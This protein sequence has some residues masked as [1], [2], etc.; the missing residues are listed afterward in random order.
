MAIRIPTNAKAERYESLMRCLKHASV[1]MGVNEFFAARFMT[2]FFEQLVDEVVDGK[3]VTIPGFGIFVPGINRRSKF[4]K[5]AKEKKFCVP[6]FAASVGFRVQVKEECDTKKCREEDYKRY[7]R[8]ASPSIKCKQGQRPSKSL[9]RVRESVIE[10][11]ER[12]GMDVGPLR[13]KLDERLVPG[14][15]P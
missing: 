1:E 12:V 4:K 2:H 11:A 14:I 15:L 3:L 8:S 6:K 10:Q 7:V 5:F 9:A 13:K